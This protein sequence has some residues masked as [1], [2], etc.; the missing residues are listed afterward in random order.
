[1]TYSRKQPEVDIDFLLG[2]KQKRVMRHG[3]SFVMK[4]VL[5]QDSKIYDYE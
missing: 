1:M 2:T 3:E 5:N 4:N